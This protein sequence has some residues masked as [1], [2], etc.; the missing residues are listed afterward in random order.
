MGVP[1]RVVTVFDLRY[2]AA[3]LR[4]GRRTGRRPEPTPIRR[5]VA[6]YMW[7]RVNSRDR[8]VSRWAAGEERQARQ[9][10]RLT[11]GTIRQRVNAT[12][13]GRLALEAADDVDVVPAR[14]RRNGLW[15]G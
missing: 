14:H 7:A 1:W 3:S 6:V 11:L 5:T 8:W 10:L 4:K 12:A 2:S 13:A 15:L 9:R